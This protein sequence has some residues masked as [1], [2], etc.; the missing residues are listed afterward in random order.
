MID[1]EELLRRRYRSEP[2]SDAEHRETQ[3]L[4][5]VVA[6]IDEPKLRASAADLAM[7]NRELTEA[8]LLVSGGAALHR[9]SRKGRN[10]ILIGGAI[11]ALVLVSLPALLPVSSD[12]ELV[13][14]GMDDRLEVAAQRGE[15]RFRLRPNDSIRAGDRLGFFYSAR[16]P[17]YLAV[18]SVDDEG[19]FSILQ[20]STHI[21]IGE[22]VPLPNGA[23]ADEGTGCEWIVAVFSEASIPIGELRKQIESAPRTAESCELV[24]A[25]SRA[26]SVRVIPL[27]RG[28][29]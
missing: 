2:V 11:A 9:R 21:Q 5:R 16:S 23:V 8:L 29:R 10:L 22:E 27:T 26:R 19:V 20:P 7:N 6:G 18:I 15:E 4:A 25:I 3:L 24:P 13:P 17:G 1:M 14:K 28:A 12:P